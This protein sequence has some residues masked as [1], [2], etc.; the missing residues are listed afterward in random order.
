M[1]HLRAAPDYVLNATDVPAYII[2]PYLLTGFFPDKILEAIGL[3]NW[4]LRPAG[5]AERDPARNMTHVARARR[6]LREAGRRV[7]TVGDENMTYNEI[8]QAFSDSFMQLLGP[9][10]RENA[11]FMDT[12]EEDLESALFKILMALRRNE[13]PTD[14]LREFAS[15]RFAWMLHFS[16]TIAMEEREE[17]RRPRRREREE[18][19]EII[20]EM[21]EPAPERDEA[22]RPR[23]GEREEVSEIITEMREPEP[24]PAPAPREA[25][26]NVEV[27]WTTIINHFR[28]FFDL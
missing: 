17:A 7:W 22:R 4:H 13:R 14:R 15:T 26:P 3:I 20:T 16:A 21:R 1:S 23:R 6:I 28:G 18:A 5:W 25:R 2:E 10:L 8:I 11:R 24:E 12:I 27:L 19:Q 9:R